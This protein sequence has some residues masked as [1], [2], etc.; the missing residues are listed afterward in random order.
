MERGWGRATGGARGAGE[1]LS[2]EPAIS[3]TITKPSPRADPRGPL[4]VTVLN[5]LG[6]GPPP[7]TGAD[8]APVPGLVL[9][10]QLSTR[11]LS[12][13]PAHFVRGC[14][15]PSKRQQHPSVFG[16][17]ATIPRISPSAGA[18]SPAMSSCR[19]A[20]KSP[21]PGGHRRAPQGL[22]R[23][24][25]EQLLRSADPRA[26]SIS[27]DELLPSPQLRYERAGARLGTRTC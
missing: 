2:P 13:P 8:A 16:G 18:A 3:H 1:L 23:H 11:L 12:S 9:P 20:T 6:L 5:P 17:L 7:R 25:E 21:C 10:P 26:G 27:S 14:I 24:Q 19:W 4:R 22:P 15:A